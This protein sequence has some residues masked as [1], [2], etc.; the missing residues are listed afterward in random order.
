MEIRLLREEDDRGTFL[1]GDPD[2]D[3]FFHRYAGQNQF[4]HHLGVTYVAVDESI[5][6]YAT[7]APGQIDADT[8]PAALRRKL[9]RYPL[10]ILR[11]AR[12][13][14]AASASGRGLGTQMLR[15]VILQAVRM[16]DE[17][18][19]AGVLVDAKPTAVAF[20]RQ[21]GFVEIDVVQGAADE[22]PKPTPMFLASTAI[23]KGLAP[24]T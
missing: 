23:R 16:S 8:L 17:Y 24:T 3:R 12:L 6:A 11:L 9:P 10:P 4:R 7:I 19:C 21:F 5:L 20:Y 18:G 14:V 15:F 13:A 1:S 22:T 2:L